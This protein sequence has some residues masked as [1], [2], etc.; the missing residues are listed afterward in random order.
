M[1][2]DTH[3][4]TTRPRTMDFRSALRDCFPRDGTFRRFP[5]LRPTAKRSNREGPRQLDGVR[6][7]LLRDRCIEIPEEREVSDQVAFI[8][9]RKA[10]PVARRTPT[11]SR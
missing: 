8:A 5:G 9:Y 1:W 6:E 3:L 11:P 2:P 4:R 7:P 10:D